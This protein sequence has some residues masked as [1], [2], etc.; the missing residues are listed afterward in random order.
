MDYVELH[1]SSAFSFLGAASLPETLA[2][3]CA[4]RGIP[5]IGLLDR[6]GVYGSPR[7]HMAAQS[8][9]LKAHVGAEVSVDD[10]LFGEAA[11]CRYPLL[12]ETRTGYQNLCRLITKYKLREHHKGQGAAD[13][14]EL[15]EY[16]GGLVC[17]TG[18]EEGPLTEALRRG[19]YGEGLRTVEQMVQ[20]FGPKN[21]YVELQRHR[22]RSQEARNKAAVSIART[23]H[24]PLLATNGVTY[25]TPRERGI[26]DVLT[27]IR[28]HTTLEGAGASLQ[29]NAERYLRSGK[30]MGQLFA[31]LPEAIHNTVALSDRLKFQL[32]DLGYE[33]PRYPVP[34]GESMISFLRERTREGWERRY[35]HRTEFGLKERARKQI[36]R[37]L[38]L[39][40]KL[41]LAGYFLIVWDLMRF[42][43]EQRILAQG[44]GSA[45][46]SAVC[47]ALGIT[48][49][50]PV[51]MDLL[52]ERFLSEERG[53]WPD[54]DLDLPSG[55]QRERVI[56]YLY[57]KY[58]EHGAAMTA[59]V[60][61]YREKS[62][63][64][65]IGKALGLSEET[66]SAVSSAVSPFEWKSPTETVEEHFR[67]AGL[68]VANPKVVKYLDLVER[69]QDIPRHLSQHSGGMIVCQGQLDAVVPLEPATMVGRRVVQWDKD[70]CAD[71]GIIK[72][73]LLGLGMMS[74][75]EESLELIRDGYGEDVDLARLPIDDPAVY[76]AIQQADTIGVFQIESR[77]QMSSLPRTRPKCFYDLVRQEAIIRPGPIQ[78]DF[79]NPFILRVLGRQKITYPHPLLEPI[80]ARTLGVPLFQEQIL[81]IAMVMADL[82]G[83][84]AEQLRRAMGS[85]RSV[86][87]VQAMES[88]LRSRMTAKGIEP[89][90]QDEVIRLIQAVGHYMFPESHAASFASLTYSS[91]YLR[92]HYRA[93]FSA[94][95]LNQQPMGFYAPDTI[96]RD[97]KHHGLKVRYIDVNASAWLCTIERSNGLVPKPVLRIGLRYIKGL[98]KSAGEA[99]VRERSSNGPF[100]SVD[101]LY[102]R[103][104]ELRA[105][106]L[107]S[108]AEVGALNSTYRSQQNANRRTALWDVA[109]ALKS[110]GPLFANLQPEVSDAPLEQMTHEE[111]LVADYQVSGMT[112]G[113]HPLFYKRTELNQMGV[114]TA[115]RLRSVSDA[116]R[117]TV[118]G[119]AIV[120]QRPGTAN[121]MLFQSLEDE[122]GITNVAVL[123][124]VFRRFGPLLQ[125][126]RFLLVEGKMQS[127]DGTFTV[128]AEMIRTLNLTGAEL[129]GRSFR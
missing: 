7:M 11:R 71:F 31:D 46:N 36:E 128:R 5:A 89:H 93:A 9:G 90:V 6:D 96:V 41:E 35:G 58:G 87:K 95:L 112:T 13:F 65:E 84:E 119:F 107:T 120:T 56:Q 33:L 129:T 104:P 14:T 2:E 18:G 121:G 12:A 69:M 117:V 10:A 23:L 98:R 24:L 67:Q 44:R 50:D 77:A 122:T 127:V 21:V 102:Q 74:V 39:I 45:A 126:S 97:A 51:G 48:I 1:A 52:F 109:R 110:P 55:D 29:G 37:E 40:E 103:V 62:A 118:A 85:K 42:C 82:T 88:L 38:A 8:L 43:N 30:E 57:A 54:I 99:L 68:N 116:D 75:L 94:A 66:V 53:E 19:G 70:D 60:T 106:E 25:A 76:A 115:V 114:T 17:L 81:K 73:D 16:A 4:A 49:V 111:R 125:R 100:R 28:L 22:N 108:L 91:A 72:F 32:K 26:Q 34:Q 92:E 3:V 80:L 64:R 20:T 123:P 124:H 59:N 27:A 78:G 83:G 61:T 63:A 113:P 47:Y 15:E 86:A 101:D 79:V 105:D